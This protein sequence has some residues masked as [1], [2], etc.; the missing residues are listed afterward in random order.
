[1]NALLDLD[2][3]LFRLLNGRLHNTLFDAVLPF[4]ETHR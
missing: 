1:M 3:S 2:R 4:L